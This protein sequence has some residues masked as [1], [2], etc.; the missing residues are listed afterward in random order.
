[1]LAS[2]RTGFSPSRDNLKQIVD[3]YWRHELDENVALQIKFGIPTR[4]LPDVSYAHAQSEAE[5]ARSIVQRLDRIDTSGLSPEDRLTFEI[6]RWENQLAVDGLP[7]FWYRFQVTPYSFRNLGIQQVFT[8]QRLSDADRKRLLN[9]LPRVVDQMIEVLRQQRER[10]IVLPRAEV[11]LAK[12]TIVRAIP[13]DPSLKR[14]AESLSE[15]NAPESIG[16]SQYPGGDAAYRYF[17]RART[18]IGMTPQQIHDLGLREV[19]RINREMQQVRDTLGFKGT[20]AEFHQFL[21]GDP[22][23]FAKTP[24]E[25]GD[26][27]TGY[28]HKIEPHVPQFFSRVPK[29]RYDVQR[30]DP[31]LEGGITFGY[32]QPPTA[33]DP[34]GHYYYNGSHLNE[35]NLLFAPALIAHELVPGHHFQIARQEENEDLPRFRR[36][37]FDTA[38]IEGWGEYAAALGNDMGIYDDPYDRYGRLMMDM[39]L[40]VR[41]VVDTGMNAFGW[42][43]ERAAAF[44]RENTLLS[45]TEIATETLRYAVDMPAQALAY[46]IGSLKMME[47]RRKAEQQLGPRF[48]IRQFHEWIIGSGSK[49]LPILEE[50]IR[51]EMR[52]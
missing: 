29:A 44:M 51:A 30:L 50:H 39:M 41:L 19:E 3:D 18:T 37:N 9:E 48:D 36:E 27:L 33:T 16:L 6:L 2:C 12:Q 45:E 24:E 31:A 32:Y 4:H 46:K 20:K 40:S 49:P 42:S 11:P 28:L 47:L 25:V 22:R 5:F 7:Y 13:D 52:R 15:A 1:M 21:K 43:R 35:R 10:G 14:L 23:F 8:M 17:V 26:R 38:Y 34:V